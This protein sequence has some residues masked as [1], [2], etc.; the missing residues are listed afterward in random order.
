MSCS[1]KFWDMSQYTTQ[2]TRI[3]M[4]LE[5]FRNITKNGA[6]IEVMEENYTVYSTYNIDAKKTF[7]YFKNGLLEKIDQGQFKQQRYQLEVINKNN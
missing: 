5:E 6:R 4:S 7:Y 1:Q 2:R 3:G